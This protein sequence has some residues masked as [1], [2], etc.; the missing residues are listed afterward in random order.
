MNVVFTGAAV[1]AAG[2]AI[3]RAN[4]I[5]AC[6]ERGIN[7]Q[8]GIMASTKI[9]VASRND[10]VKARGAAARNIAV[11]SYPE[12]LGTFFD[13]PIPTG[14]SFSKYTDLAPAK[15][16]KPYDPVAGLSPEFIL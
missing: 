13:G 5:A 2:A 15:P 8:P 4:L 10:T 14:G 7:V 9:L 1:D 16:A 11:L 6:R 12:F 3:L